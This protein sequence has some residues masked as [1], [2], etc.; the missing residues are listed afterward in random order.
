MKKTYR[1]QSNKYIS[2]FSVSL[3]LMILIWLISYISVLFAPSMVLAILR[4]IYDVRVST[5]AHTELF[6][7]SFANTRKLTQE[8]TRLQ[9]EN[10]L[11][12]R[13][14][15][16]MK[17]LGFNKEQKALGLPPGSGSGVIG[18]IIAWPPQTA[19]DTVILSLSENAII[20]KDSLVFLYG[21]IP[22][23]KVVRSTGDT[24]EVKLF[25]SPGE[26][27]QVFVGESDLATTM[28]GNGGGS[29]Y[30]EIPRE[31][32]LGVG[33]AVFINSDEKLFLGRVGYVEDKE[34]SPT[35]L[36]YVSIY[37]IISSGWVEIKNI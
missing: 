13:E 36:G 17:A 21:S 31:S 20:K 9:K 3:F 8:N 35:K 23:G 11:L 1:R 24:V 30:V 5:I 32:P 15:E 34:T 22:V 16:E 4:P 14:V 37:Q 25:T 18:R 27:T 26:V 6:F 29:A 2:Y 10:T 12:A 28:I 19:Y 33:S 7:D